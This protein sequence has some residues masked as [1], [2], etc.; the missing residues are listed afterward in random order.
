MTEPRLA[1]SDHVDS[2]KS[3][4]A[5]IADDVTSSLIKDPW[6]SMSAIEMLANM[7]FAQ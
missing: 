1:S 2:I 7:S 5:K 3:M 6:M 4:C